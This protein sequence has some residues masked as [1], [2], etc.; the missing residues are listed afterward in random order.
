MAFLL[1]VPTA[2]V[3]TVEPDHHGAVD[4]VA[5]CVAVSVV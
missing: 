2:H 1:A 5:V 3:A 4:G